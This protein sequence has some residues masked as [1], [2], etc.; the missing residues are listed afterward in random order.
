MGQVKANINTSPATNPC[1]RRK[2]RNEDI[3]AAIEPGHFAKAEASLQESL[4]LAEQLGDRWSIGTSLRFLGLAALRQGAARAQELLRQS[5]D[6]HRSVVTGWDIAR[7][8]IYLAEAG[9]ALGD[10][11][12][13]RACYAEALVMAEEAHS[14]PLAAEARAGLAR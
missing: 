14:P 12:G 3:P 13:A 7:T 4:E 11:E 9:L 2:P 8:S 10:V 1:R 5:L 6:V